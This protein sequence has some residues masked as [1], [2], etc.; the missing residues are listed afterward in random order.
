MEVGGWVQVSLGIFCVGKSS[1]T[2]PKPVNVCYGPL[3][4][5]C[6]CKYFIL[7]NCHAI[8]CELRVVV[9]RLMLVVLYIM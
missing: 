8:S 3:L 6:I 9:A 5:T 1:Q 4:M 2:S 7:H